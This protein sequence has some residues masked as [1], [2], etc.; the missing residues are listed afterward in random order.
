MKKQEILNELND[1]AKQI[2]DPETQAKLIDII[3]RINLSMFSVDQLMVSVEQPQEELGPKWSELNISKR[4]AA[5]LSIIEK[6]QDS[7]PVLN[8]MAWIDYRVGHFAKIK[9]TDILK[10]RNV[11]KSTLTEIETKMGMYGYDLIRY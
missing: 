6:K 5:A 3:T 10:L 4:L 7:F 9:C 2:E 1:I 11:G 8:G